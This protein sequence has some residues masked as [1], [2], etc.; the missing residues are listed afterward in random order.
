MVAAHILAMEEK[1]AAVRLVCSKTVAHWS[2]VLH[3]SYLFF[4]K[5]NVML[6]ITYQIY[7]AAV[8]G[9]TAHATWIAVRYYNRDFL[10]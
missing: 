7:V 2:K 3:M 4:K 5:S 6:K 9:M 8:K 10:K 1:E